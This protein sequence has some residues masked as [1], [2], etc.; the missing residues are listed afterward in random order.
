MKNL[1]IIIIIIAALVGGFVWYKHPQVPGYEYQ[2]SNETAHDSSDDR[3]TSGTKPAPPDMTPDVKIEDVLGIKE[4]TVEGFNFGFTPKTL[5]VKKGDRVRIIFKNTGGMHDF[6]IDEFNVKTMVI[7]GGAQD[8][9]EFTADK[10][11]TFEFYCSVGT[12]R[13]MG[14]KGTFTVTE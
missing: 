12:H 1:I 11:G 3:G 8:T 4:F 7:Q 10:A 13:Q 5:S 2:N 6:R 14:M 9:I